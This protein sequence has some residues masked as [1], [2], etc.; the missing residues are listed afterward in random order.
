MSTT[1]VKLTLLEIEVLTHFIAKREALWLAEAS[2]AGLQH[3][4]RILLS[5]QAAY[6]AGL[7][8]AVKEKAAPADQGGL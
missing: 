2:E 4:E 3:P 6:Q 1:P 8:N 5:M 7:R